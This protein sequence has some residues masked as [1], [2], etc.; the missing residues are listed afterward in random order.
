MNRN[1]IRVG[2]LLHWDHFV[3]RHAGLLADL[4]VLRASYAMLFSYAAVLNAAPVHYSCA[5]ILTFFSPFLLNKPLPTTNLKRST[6]ILFQPP[7]PFAL[8]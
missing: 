7:H 2:E 5:I 6:R 8:F 3:T 1:G 4:Q